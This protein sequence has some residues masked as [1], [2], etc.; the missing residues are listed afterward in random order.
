MEYTKIRV[1]PTRVPVE[2][3]KLAPS[4]FQPE[5]DVKDSRKFIIPI[6]EHGYID[7]S[8]LE[9]IDPREKNTVV[10]NAGVGQGKSSICIDI[11]KR[12]LEQVDETG[13]S[14]YVVIFVTPFVALNNQY[15]NK[16]IN[17]GIDGYKIFNYL[18]VTATNV[19][20]A[21][22]SPVHLVTINTLLG[23]YGD[24]KFMQAKARRDYINKII[25]H[26]EKRRK[27]VV[28]IFDEIHDSIHNFQEK[29]IFNL[30]KWYYVIHKSF[31][32]S[33]TF[34]ESSKVV[35]K[36]LADLTKDKIQLLESERNKI[37]DGQSKLHLCLLND[38]AYSANNE[39]IADLIKAE[40]RKGKKVNILS[41]SEKL[42]ISIAKPNT[43]KN[44]PPQYS[45][46]GKVLLE[47]SQGINLCT[48]ETKSPFDETKCNV[49]TTF[50]TGIS[51][52]GNNNSLIIFA[53]H[54]ASYKDAF[55]AYFGIFSDG[56]T[57][58]IQ[59]IARLRK[60][61]NNDIFVITP[62]PAVLIKNNPR[63]LGVDNYLGKLSKIPEL[64]TLKVKNRY[65]D[66][67]S[68]TSQFVLLRKFYRSTLGTV[69]KGIDYHNFHNIFVK[70]RSS[71]K[72]KLD[73]PTEDEFILSD[74]DRYI[75]STYSI[76]GAKPS[77]YIIWAAFNNQFI[78]CTLDSVYYEEQV[79]L[80][81]GRI[82]EGLF[83]I[84]FERYGFPQNMDYIAEKL[85]FDS[86][87][88]YVTQ[89]LKVKVKLLSRNNLVNANKSPLIKLGVL[90]L[91]QYLKR[92]NEN[93][94]RAIYPKGRYS[95]EGDKLL[96]TDYYIPKN[97][98][99]QAAIAN[100]I[101]YFVQFQNHLAN[102][103]KLLTELYQSLF[104]ELTQLRKTILFSNE[105]GIRYIPRKEDIIR[106]NIVTNMKTIQLVSL[107]QQI[108]KND[109]FISDDTISFCQ[110]AD[111]IDI[112]ALR[113][114]QTEIN[115]VL[116]KILDETR[117]LLFHSKR[118]NI[119]R[120]TT[121]TNSEGLSIAFT[122]Q[123][124][125]VLQEVEL[126]NITTAVNVVYTSNCPWN[127]SIVSEEF[128]YSLANQSP[129]V[130]L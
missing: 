96:A 128:L 119:S 121:L 19:E 37:I 22:Q 42:A 24:A 56:T 130:I 103:E 81:E 87:Y 113:R 18:N 82:M 20:S 60:G 107:I 17:A 30:W 6:D 108:R 77:A 34:T 85:L 41:F 9:Y 110:W 111:K 88:D 64:R 16:L 10:I 101:G 27:R 97:M 127:E 1:I 57:S 39:F 5:Y 93:V 94:N 120:R 33:A 80:K 91:V 8:I 117:D 114:N 11:A 78:N 49:G 102:D 45:K 70:G 54:L 115:K 29:F 58:I 50:K 51:I 66:Y 36:Y 32:L 71:K 129:E 109:F 7:P 28:F 46:I 98:Y 95:S 52:E 14:K 38:F 69:K 59:A 112:S 72:P 67:Q 13:E 99:I 100:S 61:E 74:G 126:E 68:L 125:K 15:F 83:T 123:V 23:N 122:R 35:I 44:V 84:F 55:E 4:D 90:S 47:N 12:Y 3:K 53:P 116:G 31:V 76:F 2:F 48:S 40:Y 21:S 43:P 104:Y 75:A 79:V 63:H 26:C 106:S 118:A 92:N 62:S 65:E 89:V 86:F 124:Y 105:R 25:T 73:F